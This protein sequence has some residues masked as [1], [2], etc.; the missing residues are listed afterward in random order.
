MTSADVQSK[1][2][3]INVG[4]NLGTLT[5]ISGD[6]QSKEVISTGNT[7]GND[8]SETQLLSHDPFGLQD[9]IAKDQRFEEYIDEVLQVSEEETAP[10]KGNQEPYD[11]DAHHTPAKGIDGKQPSKEKVMLVYPFV[12]GESI[13]LATASLDLCL[14]YGTM[15]DDTHL[16]LGDKELRCLRVVASSGRNHTFDH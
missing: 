15:L 3:I 13:E 10:L 8:D 14:G 1:E 16:E 6:V 12:G 9:S 2:A 4:N 7:L 5:V 11:V